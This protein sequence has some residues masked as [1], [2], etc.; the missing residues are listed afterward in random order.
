MKKNTRGNPG[1]ST[2]LRQYRSVF[3][4]QENLEH[5]SKDDYETALRKF[6]IWCLENRPIF[7]V[8][9]QKK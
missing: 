3:Q 1:V 9:D 2:L 6:L 5:Y 8:P 7:S 4:T